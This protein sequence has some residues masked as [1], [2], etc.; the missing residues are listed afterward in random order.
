MAWRSSPVRDMNLTMRVQPGVAIFP[1][2]AILF[3]LWSCS[4]DPDAA[5]A[6]LRRR[7]IEYTHGS[8]NQAILAGDTELVDLLLQARVRPRRGLR[9]AAKEG[10]CEI[11]RKL[12]DVD[13]RVDGIL[14]AEALAWALHNQHDDCVELLE[15]AG[16]DLRAPTRGG[17]NALTKAAQQ[18]NVHYLEVLISIGMDPDE[19]NR[20]GKPALI[21]AV[22][23]RQLQSIRVLI[24]NG[25][26][27]N[28]TDLDGW[29]ALTYAAWSNHNKIA[30]LLIDSGA[31]LDQQTDTGWTPLGIAA[32]KGHW[33]VAKTLLD[34]GADPDAESEAGLTPLMRAAQQG[35]QRMVRILLRAGADPHVRIDG[36]DAAWWAD[37]SGHD[38]I[39]RL[40]GAESRIG[41]KRS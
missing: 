36:V 32:L 13:Y 12:I 31:S 4:A 24:E 8:F 14:A 11:L 33:R 20:N 22:E 3:S 2:A 26:D 29:T 18:G 15:T 1:L 38:A 5:R 21:R 25:A 17:D 40:L 27:V 16:A 39:T 19:P 37:A 41:T 9:L 35:D 30:R 6:E 28:A 34:A 23:G 10:Q 7:G